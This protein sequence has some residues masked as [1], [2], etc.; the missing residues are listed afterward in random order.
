MAALAAMAAMVA[1]LLAFADAED[2][3]LNACTP[4]LINE[5]FDAGCGRWFPRFHPKNSNP[6]AHSSYANAP[7][8]LNGVAHLFM[9]ATFPGMASWAGALGLAH[10]ASRD[11]ATWISIAPALVPGAF[12]GPIGGVG[13]PTGNV[14]EGY[15]SCSATLVGPSPRI[16]VPAVFFAPSFN[17]GCPIRCSNP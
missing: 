4:H 11:L 16:V 17:H 8:E 6:L 5:T 14:T 2:I 10:V 9:E 15:Y 3:G 1:A 7:F 12:G 13:Q